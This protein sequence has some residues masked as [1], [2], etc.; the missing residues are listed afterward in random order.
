ML[1]NAVFPKPCIHIKFVHANAEILSVS[2]K[3]TR[4]V[5]F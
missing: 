4:R 1:R 5:A 2:R 3:D